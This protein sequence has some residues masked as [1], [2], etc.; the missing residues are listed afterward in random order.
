MPTFYSPEGNA[1]IWESKPGGYLTPGEWLREHA[2]ADTGIADV[3]DL[4]L[5]QIFELESQQTP[6]RMREAALTEEGGVWLQNLEDQIASKRA[7]L[8]GLS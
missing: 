4:V 6:R 2:D 1:E 8:A 5:S 3:K 7:E